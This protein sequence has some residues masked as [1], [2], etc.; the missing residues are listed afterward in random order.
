VKYIKSLRE[1][2]RNIKFLE[3]NFNE[4]GFKDDSFFFMINPKVLK[5]LRIRGIERRYGIVK[6]N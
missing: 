1:V 3:M 4:R 2:L 5:T 6:L